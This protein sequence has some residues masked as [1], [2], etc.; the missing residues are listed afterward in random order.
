MKPDR[1]K[2]FSGKRW[3]QIQSEIQAF[4]RLLQKEDVR[5]YLEIGCLYGDTFHAVGMALPEGSTLVAVDLPGTK[6]GVIGGGKHKDSGDYLRGAAADLTKHGRAAHVIIGDSHAPETIEA[7]RAFAPFDAVFIDGDHT[8]EGC[9]ADWNDYGSMGRIVGFHDI[10]G[11]NYRADVRTVYRE[12][13]AGKRWTEFANNDPK[14]GIG[15]L[16]RS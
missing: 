5:S 13:R 4:I 2:G 14:G 16:W 8:P 11:D 9:L 7:A 3:P 1:A 6:R 15:V 10:C 12:V